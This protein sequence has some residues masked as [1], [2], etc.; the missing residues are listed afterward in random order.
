M[1]IPKE[2]KSYND[3]KNW[4]EWVIINSANEKI[5]S[6]RA[7]SLNRSLNSA[8]KIHMELPLQYIKLKAQLGEKDKQEPIKIPWFDQ[9]LAI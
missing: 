2:L 7:N 4:N 6:N 1:E 9:S 8:V 3:L 5:D